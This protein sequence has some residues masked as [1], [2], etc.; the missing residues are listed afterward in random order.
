MAL[1]SVLLN[2]QIVLLSGRT[3]HVFTLAG[4][5]STPFATI[6][7]MLFDNSHTHKITTYCAKPIGGHCLCLV[8]HI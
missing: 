6:K 1:R 2:A 8:E 3:P 7:L 5:I 4:K